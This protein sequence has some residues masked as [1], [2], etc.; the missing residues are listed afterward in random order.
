MAYTETGSEKTI[1]AKI[2]DLTSMLHEVTGGLESLA[3]RLCGH[4]PQPPASP[5]TMTSPGHASL[6]DELEAQMSTAYGALLE[7]RG[8]IERISRRF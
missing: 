7:A 2:S 5:S 3:N 1:S 8:N 6:F 4:L